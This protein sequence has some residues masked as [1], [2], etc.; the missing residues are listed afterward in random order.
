[1]HKTL[2]AHSDALV[3]LVMP[4]LSRLQGGWFFTG[5]FLVEITTMTLV[6]VVFWYK[7]VG[8]FVLLFPNKFLYRFI[9]FR[10]I[11]NFFQ[12]KNSIHYSFFWIC[13][14]TDFDFTLLIAQ[15]VYKIKTYNLSE[16]AFYI[17][18]SKAKDCFKK[19]WENTKRYH[20][21]IT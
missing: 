8:T 20:F 4:R 13:I 9:I 14:F 7:S 2:L 21:G 16:L 3:R 15:Y 17:R 6:E 18:S 11:I 1:M 12:S 10:H 5:I 19:C